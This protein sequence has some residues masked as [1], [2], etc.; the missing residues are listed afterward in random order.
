MMSN[1]RLLLELMSTMCLGQSEWRMN[2][3]KRQRERKGEKRIP[4]SLLKLH[5]NK[6]RTK[7]KKEEE[8][9]LKREGNEGKKEG[10]RRVRRSKIKIGLE[11]ELQ[12]RELTRA[13]TSSSGSTL[14]LLVVFLEHFYSIPI[15]FPLYSILVLDLSLFLNKCLWI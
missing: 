15:P 10:K 4:L 3:R 5:G 7:K 1:E 13:L 8:N 12:S 2:K 14:V 9:S 6:W 11:G